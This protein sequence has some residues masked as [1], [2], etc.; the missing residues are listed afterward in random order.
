MNLHIPMKIIAWLDKNRGD[1][2]RAAYIIHILHILT[3][4][5]KFEI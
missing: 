5:N 3:D 4:T 1:K 2:S